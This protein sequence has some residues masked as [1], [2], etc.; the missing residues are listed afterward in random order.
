MIRMML[1]DYNYLSSAAAVSCIQNVVIVYIV[2][3]I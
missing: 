3:P 2:L 1:L